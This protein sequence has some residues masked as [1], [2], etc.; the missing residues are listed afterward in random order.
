MLCK[1]LR[2]TARQ[3]NFWE[4]FRLLDCKSG[5]TKY[6][7]EAT[8]WSI[9]STSPPAFARY[10]VAG[11]GCRAVAQGEGGRDHPCRASVRQATSDP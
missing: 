2:A 6:V 3:A 4:V 8:N 10:E 7:S 11:K 1:P 5:V 9:T